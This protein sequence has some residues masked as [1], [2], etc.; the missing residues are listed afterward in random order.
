MP[1]TRIT[2]AVVGYAR[3]PQLHA[4]AREQLVERERLGHVVDRAELEAA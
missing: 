2:V 3:P 4:R 1:P